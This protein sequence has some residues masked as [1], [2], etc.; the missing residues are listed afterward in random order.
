MG[1]N[2]FSGVVIGTGA[3]LDVTIPGRKARRVELINATNLVKAEWFE[4]MAEE[5]AFK[6]KNDASTQNSLITAHGIKPIDG[7]FNIGTDSD[8]NSSGDTIYYICYF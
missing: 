1:D 5:S 3:S 6:N 8:L 2:Y 7:G 4:G